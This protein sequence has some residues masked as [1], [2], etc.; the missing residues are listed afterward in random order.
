MENKIL[1]HE[2]LISDF[3]TNVLLFLW[4]TV[5]FEN[6]CTELNA[7]LKNWP[8]RWCACAIVYPTKS[9]MYPPVM[10]IT[11]LLNKY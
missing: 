7:Q 6:N 10:K 5:H 8:A 9:P 11:V 4:T 1:D 2:E 3:C